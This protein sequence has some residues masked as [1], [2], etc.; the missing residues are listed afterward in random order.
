MKPAIN[1][2]LVLF[3]VICLFSLQ[4]L[5]GQ[6][7]GELTGLPDDLKIL[8]DQHL[9]PLLPLLGNARI[10]ATS[11]IDHGKNE[12]LYFR[13]S[14]IKLLV[15]RK[16][17]DVVAI[18]SGTLESK[19]LY[20]YVLN[21]NHENINAILENG[22]SWHFHVIPQ[23]EELIRWLRDYN[24]DKNNSHKVK[25][26]GFDV[27]GSPGNAAVKRRMNTSLLFVLEY[28]SKVDTATQHSFRRE[29]FPFLDYLHIDFNN[30]LSR[31]KQYSQLQE[32]ERQ[33]LDSI[34]Q[35][36]IKHF[37][38][39]ELQYCKKLSVD[40]FDWAYRAALN[41]RQILGWLGHIPV[42]YVPPQNE[43]EFS[44]SRLFRDLFHYRDR[45]MFDNV[46]WILKREPKSRIFL[47]ASTNHL[48]K[49][50]LEVLSDSASYHKKVL[51]NY[52]ALRY[53]EDY[54]LIGNIIPNPDV[55]EAYVENSFIDKTHSHYYTPVEPQEKLK[56]Y[57][58]KSFFQTKK[59]RLD[60]YRAVDVILFDRVQSDITFRGS[61]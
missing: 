3:L 13:N 57:T 49:E 23:N 28:L 38:V 53:G 9:E 42:S 33:R 52:L 22:F 50:P 24:A 15:K 59:Q 44:D 36:L 55:K 18:E 5:N 43:Q 7:N 48:V 16:L 34:V 39:N 6:G 20:D 30:R 37:K 1:K 26:Y 47:F 41:S 61:N 51:G 31:D 40:E 27:P 32:R 25:L 8:Q 60:L 56:A 35:E 12:P 17:I 21:L 10:I 45:A 19:V 4:E 58:F 29:L 11:E 2:H 46:E 54:K 14:L